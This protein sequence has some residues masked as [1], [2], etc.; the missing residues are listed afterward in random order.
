MHDNSDP[1]SFSFQ[2]PVGFRNDFSFV[3]V[4]SERSSK[5]PDFYDTNR[6]FFAELF[7]SDAKEKFAF[8]LM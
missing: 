1:S 5:S 4:E 8:R 3:V 7:S 2:F 6:M